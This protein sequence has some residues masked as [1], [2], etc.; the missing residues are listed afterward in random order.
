MKLKG[1]IELKTFKDLVKKSEILILC[2]P[3]SRVVKQIIKK[4]KFSNSDKKFV[5]DCTTN[6]HNSVIYFKKI[7][8][9]H[10]FNYIEA[11][12]SGG[13]F[14]AKNGELGAFIGSSK[15][16]FKISKKILNPCCKKNY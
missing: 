2:L 15:K 3:N 11:P 4:L 10:N 13:S 16:N 1:T 9:I 14:Q 6:D 7:S 12:I 8:K 5:I